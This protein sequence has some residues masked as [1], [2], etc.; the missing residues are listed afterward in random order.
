[1][2]C[3]TR[4]ADVVEVLRDTET[5][6]SRNVI[7]FSQLT[8][9]LEA[10]F[11]DGPPDRVLASTDPPVH[12]R[13]RTLAQK[14]FTP[15]L[16][17]GREDEIRRLCH[18][19]I[20]QF[21]A[22]GHCDLVTDFAE[23]LPV[24]AITRL[25]GAPL[26]RSRDF[27]RWGI[28]RVQ[29]LSA[30]PHL[31]E[32]EL[33]SLVTRMVAMSDWLREFVEQRRSTPQDD[34]TS[35]LVHATTDDGQP[36]LTTS[37]VITMIGTVLSAGSSTTAHF[38]PMMIRD[39]L[40]HPDQWEQVLTDPSIRRRAV[41]ECLRHVTSVHGVPRTTTRP[42]TLG[43]IDIPQGADLYVHLAAAQ[44]DPALFTNPDQL[45]IQRPN[46]H[47]QFAFGRGIHTCLGAPLARLEARIALDVLIQRLPNLHLAPQHT[48]HWTP[49]M[50]TPGL[51]HLNLHW[52][53]NSATA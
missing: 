33:A 4:H 32:D 11:P 6:S 3:V 12:N 41:E 39:L 23:H 46:V 5:Y 26:E 35:T 9:E 43:G 27:Y 25:V 20:D 16:I 38:I 29:L 34:L 37:E 42:V 31:N 24:Q 1:M 53:V 30:A 19:L 21:A 28:D 8:P 49:H 17:N 7:R 45:D 10:A 15:K 40:L 51:K 50:L 48:E 22:D 14:A 52:D 13:L 36:S 2:W 44:R 18:R 47:K